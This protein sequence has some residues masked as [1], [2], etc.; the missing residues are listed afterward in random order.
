MSAPPASELPDGV[1][2]HG[3]V[4]APASQLWDFRPCSRPPSVCDHESMQ[5]EESGMRILARREC[6]DL[7]SQVSLGRVGVSIDALPVI[8]PV[9]F[10]LFGESVF[11]N[12]NPGTKF[13]AA[14]TGAVVAFQADAPEAGSGAHW[15]VLLQGI[16]SEVSNEWDDAQAMSDAIKPWGGGALDRRLLRVEASHMTGRRFHIEPPSL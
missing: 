3:S 5:G 9:H 7:L 12:T 16:A 10:V 2:D 15:S 1:V 11:F 6:L 8:L 13:D 14:T 4:E